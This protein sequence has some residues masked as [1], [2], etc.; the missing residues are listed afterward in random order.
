MDPRLRAV[1]DMQVADA[2]ESAGLH[3]LYDGVVQDL[4]P[5]GVAAG[6]AR[7]GEGARHRDAHDEAHLAAFE[8]ATHSLYGPFAIHRRSPLPH[9][10]NLDLSCYEREY[11]P[12]EQRLDAR[13]RHL[14]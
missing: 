7:L 14:A 3:D 5:A 4:S 10:A 1:C 11:A 13:R 6:L 12:L 2:R 8:S 9:V